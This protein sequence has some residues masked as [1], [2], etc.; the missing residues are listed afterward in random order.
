MK[1]TIDG[2]EY[3]VRTDAIFP[4]TLSSGI[5]IYSEDDPDGGFDDLAFI[6]IPEEKSLVILHPQCGMFSVDISA[7]PELNKQ[8]LDIYDT[9]KDL[10]NLKTVNRT[11]NQKRTRYGKYNNY[12]ITTLQSE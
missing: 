5:P 10:N 8:L 9:Y 2:V 4:Y 6:V 7:I 3:K 1:I 12:P 11:I